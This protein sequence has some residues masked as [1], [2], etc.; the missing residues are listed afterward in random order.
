VVWCAEKTPD[1]RP[2][3]PGWVSKGQGARFLTAPPVTVWICQVMVPAKNLGG[4][5][6]EEQQTCGDEPHTG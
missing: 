1:V 6:A 2:T 5:Q 3:V 4:N